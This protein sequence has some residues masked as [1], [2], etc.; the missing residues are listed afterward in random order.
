MGG[1][2]DPPVAVGDSPTAPSGCI[3]DVPISS[4][5]WYYSGA[6]P[7]SLKPMSPVTHLLASWIIAAKTT[8]NPR[9]C[10][11]V[12]LSGILPDVD[13]LGIVADVAKGW[14][15]HTEPTYFY[16]QQYHHYVSHGLAGAVVTSLLLTWFAR[17]RLR[18]AFLTFLV[19]HLHLFCD[20]IG[21]RGPT[22]GDIW[23]IFYLAPMSQHPMWMW[24]GQWPLD[25]W[26]NRVITVTLFAWAL[27]IS[28]ARTDSFVG[29]FNR[30]ADK[31]F[32]DVLHKWRA[33]ITRRFASR[34]D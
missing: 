15:T 29:A 25:G 19:Y 5:N 2:G 12:A 33:Q 23:P 8:D 21:S 32:L 20:L 7:A 24:K 17:R 28:S 4:A 13:G 31:I 27:W 14:W 34:R 6:K 11:L 18:V 3:S 22:P 9:D 30:R 1:T 10:R 26:Q 16:Y